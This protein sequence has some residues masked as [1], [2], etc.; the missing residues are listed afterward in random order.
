MFYALL[1]MLTAGDK[2]RRHYDTIDVSLSVATTL[3]TGARTENGERC[4]YT[5]VR[6]RS[7]IHHRT[8][9]APY[10]GV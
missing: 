2:E 4:R 3:V 1:F 5:V 8:W 7:G 10:S 6:I 9:L